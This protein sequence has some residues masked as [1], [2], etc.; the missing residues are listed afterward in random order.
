MFYMY[1]EFEFVFEML[2][3]QNNRGYCQWLRF[4]QVILYLKYKLFFLLLS[5]S[6]PYKYSKY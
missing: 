5:Q 2:Q 6:S 4:K 3:T 1:M